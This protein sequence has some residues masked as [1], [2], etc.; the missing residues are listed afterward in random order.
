M[1]GEL[2]LDTIVFNFSGQLFP[3]SSTSDSRVG[4]KRAPIV[5]WGW[6][7]PAGGMYSSVN[8]IGK[9]STSSSI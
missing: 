2:I 4:E 9:V 7:K 5:N 3:M 8:D 1:V 6:L